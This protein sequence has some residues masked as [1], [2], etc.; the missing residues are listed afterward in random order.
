LQAVPIVGDNAEA[1]G[2][3]L[4]VIH[5][6]VVEGFADAR[7][8]RR[9]D[10]LLDVASTLTRVADATRIDWA[11]TSGLIGQPRDAARVPL[12][13][14]ELELKHAGLLA[15]GGPELAGVKR[16]IGM[17]NTPAAIDSAVHDAI[18]EIKSTLATARDLF[19][20]AISTADELVD[21]TAYSV[22]SGI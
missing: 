16:V 5:R 8:V 12:L 4:Q 15:L 3:W 7:R 2:E 6:E 1:P 13:L 20:A 9:I 14:E 11:D 18:A 17:L 21:Y 19:S 22:E 10:Q